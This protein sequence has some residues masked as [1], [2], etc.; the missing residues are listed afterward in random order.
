MGW[1]DFTVGFQITWSRER[2]PYLSGAVAFRE[3]EAGVETGQAEWTDVTAPTA[4]SPASV[5]FNPNPK[6][7]VGVHGSTSLLTSPFYLL[8]FWW[9]DTWYFYLKYF[10]FIPLFF[11]RG[12]GGGRAHD[13]LAHALYVNFVRGCS[14]SKSLNGTQCTPTTFRHLYNSNFWAEAFNN[15]HRSLWLASRAALSSSSGDVKSLWWWEWRYIVFFLWAFLPYCSWEGILWV[16]LHLST[17][18]LQ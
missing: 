11:W 1:I 18:L 16:P 6:P 8:S 15:L 17:P 14:L 5:T 2:S 3:E 12:G 4:I 9:P 10:S 7:I 13:N